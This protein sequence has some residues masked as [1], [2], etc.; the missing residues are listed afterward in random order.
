MSAIPPLPP[1]P[2]PRRPVAAWSRFWFPPV[3]PRRLA[4]CRLAFFTGVLLF[5][6][7]HDVS[8]LG[9]LP[10]SYYPPVY[11]LRKLHL[12]LVSRDVIANLQS[13]WRVALFFAALGLFTRLAT[14]ACLFLGTYL[15]A[16]PHSF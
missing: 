7:G 9:D 3:P 15:I 12:P 5:Y 10:R 4:L 14:V 13:V 11:L 1:L 8:A 16:L 6:L 2:I